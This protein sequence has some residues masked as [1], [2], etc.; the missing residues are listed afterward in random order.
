MSLPFAPTG[1]TD[2]GEYVMSH[3]S[4]TNTGTTTAGTKQLFI[5]SDGA[6]LHNVTDAG[7]SSYITHAQVD[8][9]WQMGFGFSYI[10]Q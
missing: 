4:L 5:L 6:Y 9:A 3:L 10:V 7:V 2:D 1:L 8:A